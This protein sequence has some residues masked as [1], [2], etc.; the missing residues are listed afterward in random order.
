MQIAG[1]AILALTVG[2]ATYQFNRQLEDM[3][4]RRAADFQDEVLKGVP[5]EIAEKIG[6]ERSLILNILQERDLSKVDLKSLTRRHPETLP[7]LENAKAAFSQKLTKDQ[8]DQ[9]VKV[10]D[11]YIMRRM[12]SF[13]P[14]RNPYKERWRHVF[15]FKKSKQPEP[16]RLING[17]IF[18]DEKG[19]SIDK[20]IRTPSVEQTNPEQE[21]SPLSDDSVENIDETANRVIEGNGV[22]AGVYNSTCNKAPSTDTI[23][24]GLEELVSAKKNLTL[25]ISQNSGSGDSSSPSIEEQA[26]ILLKSVNRLISSVPSEHPAAAETAIWC[27][28]VRNAKAIVRSLSESLT[29]ESESPDLDQV[30]PTA[31]NKPVPFE[32]YSPEIR[33][34]HENSHLISAA[35]NEPAE[36]PTDKIYANL[37]SI[38]RPEIGGAKIEGKRLEGLNSLGPISFLIDTQR[39]YLKVLNSHRDF[40]SACREESCRA[41]FGQSPFLEVAKNDATAVGQVIKKMEFAMKL[42]NSGTIEKARLIESKF[43]EMKAGETFFFPGGWSNISKDDGTL[44]GH[45]IVLEI[46]KDIYGKMILRVFNLGEGSQ[47]HGSD[48]KLKNLP[49][50]EIVNIDPK[51]LTGGAFTSFLDL[52]D[53]PQKGRK[54]W[55][56]SHFYE[57]ALSSFGGEISNRKDSSSLLREAQYVGNCVM[58]SSVAILDKTLVSAGLAE[59]M[60]AL[61]ICRATKAYYQAN[62]EQIALGEERESRRMLLLIGTQA[63]LESIERAIEVGGLIGSEAQE[64]LLAMKQIQGAVSKLQAEDLGALADMPLS[65]EKYPSTT[66]LKPVFDR[67]KLSNPNLSQIKFRQKVHSGNQSEAI[68]EVPKTRKHPGRF[69]PPPFQSQALERLVE[70]QRNMKVERIN[71]AALLTPLVINDLFEIGIQ[72][73]RELASADST[74]MLKITDHLAS[75]RENLAA[76][77]DSDRLRILQEYMNDPVLLQNNLAL[78]RGLVEAIQKFCRNG[79]KLGHLIQSASTEAYYVYLSRTMQFLLRD[80]SNK[81]ILKRILKVFLTAAIFLPN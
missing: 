68:K 9:Y 1:V 20:E 13:S 42:H 14:I 12:V 62:L 22:L 80:L 60:R 29:K 63:A 2:Q 18:T 7:T 43:N 15:S 55:K 37:I 61:T 26:L 64:L 6:E 36:V 67:S 32:L 70:Y 16:V 31:P 69:V 38:Y 41:V 74:D 25:I 47:Y 21:P 54:T 73:G 71:Q 46:E 72:D 34:M 78:D 28:E 76:F 51:R 27:R 45:G 19:V 23:L 66:Y 10:V 57:I 50:H 65:F 33:L 5:K 49:F 35:F 44:S 17:I 30:F 59:R 79:Q 75:F 24:S 3:N 81:K 4:E 58:M 39:T 48:L 11:N 52:M 77:L 56:A 8:Y 40:S 53:T